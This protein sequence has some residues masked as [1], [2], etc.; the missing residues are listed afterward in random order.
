MLLLGA[1]TSTR[2]AYVFDPV[3]LAAIALLLW[4]A[5]RTIVDRNTRRL[6][7]RSRSSVL[8]VLIPV[9]GLLYPGANYPFESREA[10]QA[11]LRYRRLRR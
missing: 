10:V 3:A 5:A 2:S 11:T 7:T 8:V 6:A 4:L 1:L 9:T